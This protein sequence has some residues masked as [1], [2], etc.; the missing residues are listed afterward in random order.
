MN[1][2]DN[3]KLKALPLP[4]GLSQLMDLTEDRPFGMAMTDSTQ[5]E[6]TFSGMLT[7]WA[8]EM[9]S[10][11][12][13]SLLESKWTMTSLLDAW[14][15]GVKSVSFD[16]TSLE[17]HAERLI[18]RFM[19]DDESGDALG[20]LSLYAVL[21]NAP[22]DF[23]DSLPIDIL[24]MPYASFVSCVVIGNTAFRGQIWKDELQLFDSQPE[25]VFYDWLRSFCK[26]H[27][28]SSWQELYIKQF[29]T[30]IEGD[31]LRENRLLSYS[32]S[33]DAGMLRQDI[34]LMPGDRGLTVCIGITKEA[35]R[36]E[37]T[38]IG[39]EEALSMANT[40]ADMQMEMQ[41][42][43]KEMRSH[44]RRI[45]LLLTIFALIAG[46]V[47]GAVLDRRNK[48]F[49]S[50]L[51]Q[52]LNGKQQKTASTEVESEFVASQETEGEKATEKK[53]IDNGQTA[54]FTAE[55]MDDGTSRTILSQDGYFTGS[56][57]VRVTDVEGPEHF[58][59]TYPEYTM[60]G[61]EAGVSIWIK[62]G[63]MDEDKSVDP[64]NA[65]Q[66]FL[67]GEDGQQTEEYQLMDQEVGGN[68]STSVSQ[69][70][71]KNFYKRFQYDPDIKYLVLT[72]WNS[73][74]PTEYW[75][76]LEEEKTDGETDQT[77]ETLQTGD[78]SESV[79]N[80]Q[81]K[82]IELDYLSGDAD[83]KFGEVTAQAV[84]DAQADMG[85]EQ[86]GVADNDFQKS[87]YTR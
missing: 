5:A 26:R 23:S 1:G 35:A 19:T 78:S 74:V 45:A 85:M 79:V 55:I 33:S 65:F 25:G 83:G 69:G 80:L 17:G 22:Q 10:E 72:C 56:F 77:Y 42:E 44:T 7:A 16:Y 12:D 27:V 84:R 14:K 87:L 18:L 58:A 76:S 8:K 67:S 11:E 4:A 3:K 70:E 64:Q 13:V 34:F 61:T 15:E 71:E 37:L 40:V 38:L 48:V 29:V 81:K 86:T 75:F 52:F 6:V 41:F 62:F 68:Y 43:R 47:G 50:I 49:S 82:L 66:I 31:D 36:N 24:A 53:Y 63:E 9:M 28:H 51:D 39:S 59:E 20:I 60:D 2:N 32:F 30:N 73:G 54:E 21:E 46:A 57:E